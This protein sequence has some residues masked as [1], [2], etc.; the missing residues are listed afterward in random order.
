VCVCEQKDTDI[1][2]TPVFQPKYPTQIILSHKEARTTTEESGGRER[3]RE[4]ERS[5]RLE[6]K[7]HHFGATQRI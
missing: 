6:K 5:G 4:R 3:E 1:K 7:P 2:D